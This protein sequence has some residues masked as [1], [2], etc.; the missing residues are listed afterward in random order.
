MWCELQIKCILRIGTHMGMRVRHLL[1]E[2]VL[3]TNYAGW[4]KYNKKIWFNMQL[5]LLWTWSLVPFCLPNEHIHCKQ[6]T[7]RIA[8]LL[9]VNKLSQSKMNTTYS[10]YCDSLYCWMYAWRCMHSMKQLH[11]LPFRLKFL[12]VVRSPAWHCW[13]CSSL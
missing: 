7:N 13:C 9:I 4:K 1:I 3:N 8:H 6:H 2:F 5:T 12:L 11:Q 10:I